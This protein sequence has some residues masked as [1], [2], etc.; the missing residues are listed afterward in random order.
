MR[1]CLA[2]GIVFALAVVTAAAIAAEPEFSADR[3]RAHVSFLA[4]DL[5]EGREAGT[6]GHEIAAHYIAS[7]FALLGVKPGGENGGYFFKVELLESSLT[8]AAPALALTTSRGTQTLKH[9]DTAFVKGPIAG[10]TVNLSAP[11]V[12]VGY[13]MKDAAMGYD[14]YKGLD[15]RG[16]IVVALYGSPKGI[17]KERP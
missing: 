7:Q 1:K 16:K 17:D 5:L 3:I 14:D 12:F 4:D 9:R 2:C 8:G 11:V 10:G 6:R 15:V 13:G